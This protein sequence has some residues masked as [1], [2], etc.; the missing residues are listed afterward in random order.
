M[1]FGFRDEMIFRWE[2]NRTIEQF[3]VFLSTVELGDE[4]KEKADYRIGILLTPWL[5]LSVS[6]YAMVIG[7]LLRS[8]ANAK[9]SFIVNDLWS[10]KNS[11][12]PYYEFQQVSIIN[13]LREYV[14]NRNHIEIV[15]LS[16]LTDM[17]L[18]EYD[19]SVIEKFAKVNTIRYFGNSI[20]DAEHEKI[21]AK[22]IDTYYEMYG[23]IKRCSEDKWDR[24]VI[25]GGMFQ[26][27]CLFLDIFRKKGIDV[28]TYDSGPGRYKLGINSCASQNGNTYTTAQ[29]ILVDKCSKGRIE[30][31]ARE[32]LNNRMQMRP[33]LSVVDS[34]RVIQNVAYQ[35]S[36]C[37]KYDIVMFSNLEFDTAA[38]GTHDVFQDDYEWIVETIWFVLENTD[39]SI[40]VRQHPLKKLFPQIS[41]NEVS[42][43]EIFK[44]NNRVTFIDY[45]EKISSYDIID[46]AKAII[47]NTSTIGL[48]AGMLGKKVI[49]DSHSYYH[50][51]SFVRYSSDK[52]QY[53][54]EIVRAL[55][56]QVLLTA[57]ERYEAGVYYFLTQKCSSVLTNFTPQP[58]DFQSWTKRSFE[59]LQK[60]ENIVYMIKTIIDLEAVDSQV[61]KSIISSM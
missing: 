48:E 52:E 58:K 23:K 10:K 8:K 3:L 57:E 18:S 26:E 31:M 49:T 21:L 22:W 30:S 38:L 7:L 43:K 20:K 27:T 39:A 36:L 61:Y 47:V 35:D 46:A 9:I 1:V 11:F 16:N 34:G 60:D 25:P 13:I 6:W 12:Y 28:I 41:T 51:A 5:G 29:S 32:I 4:L 42:I 59:D 50:R 17:E 45:D 19:K 56:Q 55:E 44:E 24:I 40:A 37:K 15:L 54:H 2:W 33:E 14:A 53:Y